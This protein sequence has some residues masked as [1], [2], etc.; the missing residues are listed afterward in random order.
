MAE[1]IAKIEEAVA[2]KPDLTSGYEALARL[3]LRQ[4]DYAHAIDRANKALGIDTDNMD[5]NAVLYE[6][7]TATGD[8]AK[9]A[10]YKAKLPANP[11]GVNT[12][13]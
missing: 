6:A 7:Y 10:E 2:A 3:Y 11:R 4:K 1:G 13:V 8:K 9:A 5:M 12:L